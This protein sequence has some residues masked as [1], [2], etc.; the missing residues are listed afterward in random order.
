MLRH[1]YFSTWVPINTTIQCHTQGYHNFHIH[2]CKN[3]ESRIFTNIYE[4]CSFHS[5]EDSRC[6]PSELRHHEA[7]YV[8]T[9][10]SEKQTVSII[11]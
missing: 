1:V 11:E 8:G 3:L 6:G 5:S 7:L 10:T 4:V 2:C 9:N